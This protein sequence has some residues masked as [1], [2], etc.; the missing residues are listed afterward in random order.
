MACGYDQYTFIQGTGLLQ[1]DSKYSDIFRIN[2]FFLVINIYIN[3][4][5][6]ESQSLKDI[7]VNLLKIASISQANE[8]QSLFHQKER[9]IQMARASSGT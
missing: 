2:S 4:I 6:L 3:N 5:L 1:C 9:E 7:T 8:R